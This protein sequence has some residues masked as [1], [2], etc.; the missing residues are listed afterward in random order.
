MLDDG[1]SYSGIGFGYPTDSAGEV[2]FNTGMVGYTETLTDPSYRGQILC[3]TYP[4]IGNYGVPSN[5]LQ[6]PYGLP[7]YFESDQ[8]QIKGL[9]IHNL[10]IIASHW[11]CIKTLDQWLYEERIP[12]IY[13]IDT[14]ELTKKLRVRGVMAGAMS[15]SSNLVAEKSRLLELMESE[16]YEGRNFMN[17][18]SARHVRQYGDD[19]KECIVLVDTGTKYSIIRNIIKS[20]YKAVLLPWDSSYEEIIKYNPAGVII[21]NGPGDPTHCQE[22]IQTATKLIDTSTPTLGICLGNQILALAAGAK[23]FKLKFGHRAQ[24]KP[25]KDLN[26]GQTYITTQNHGYG[27]RPESLKGSGFRIW[28]SNID[29]TTVEGIEHDEKPIVAV[30]FHPEASPGPY[31]CTFV[32]DRFWELIKN[33]GNLVRRGESVK[34][35]RKSALN[36]GKIAQA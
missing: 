25:C 1:S 22:T 3:I 19:K 12:G 36:G 23:T 8:I 31:D 29:D 4:L 2:V 30:Q 21:S 14:R 33:R 20:G 32:F 18:V 10:S 28:F 16:N 24:N 5:K 27:I 13:G 26:N 15:V 11:T 35:D 7:K 9:L 6:D 34:L 17:E